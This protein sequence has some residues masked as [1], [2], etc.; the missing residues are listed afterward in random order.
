MFLGEV[1]LMKKRFLAFLALCLLAVASAVM[2]NASAVSA[3]FDWHISDA[4]IQAGTGVTQTGALAQATN[5]DIVR[6]S[7]NGTFNTAADNA[8]GGGVF[9]HTASGG[10]VVA[11]G[12]W[13]ATD[14]ESFDPFGVRW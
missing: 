5:G 12:T 11:V 8:T 2:P 14:V 1:F 4:F 10:A 13:T 7:G 9:V 6:I 3:K